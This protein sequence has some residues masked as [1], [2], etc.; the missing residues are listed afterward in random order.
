MTIRLLTR[1]E[2]NIADALIVFADTR[3]WEFAAFLESPT[4]PCIEIRTTMNPAAAE[5]SRNVHDCI[6]SGCNVIVH[7]NHLS[8]ES[9]S[10]AD[11]MGLAVLFYE[12]FAHC[13]DGTVYWGRVLDKVT[14]QQLPL[15]SLEGLA[16]NELFQLV[17][18]NPNI[19]DAASISLFL[20]KEV[21]NRALRIKNIVE[22]E[23]QWGS[24]AV[25]GSIGY[26]A[27]ELGIQFGPAIDA[28]ATTIA[29]TI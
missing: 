29:R 16:M 4:G 24:L 20:R 27:H 5:P 2:T 26:S 17:S 13:A 10:D 28:A 7:H 25:G 15:Q 9:L 23:Y 14:I 3:A 19:I 6:A 21:L 8:Q 12:T 1:F 11:W 18:P 22:Y